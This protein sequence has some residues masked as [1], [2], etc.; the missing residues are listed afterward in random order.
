MVRWYLSCYPKFCK[1]LP[2]NP[3][4]AAAFTDESEKS[5]YKIHSIDFYICL[6]SLIFCVLHLFF[7][8]C[9]EMKAGHENYIDNEEHLK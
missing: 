3:L 1:T 2:N 9:F 8:Y 7:D 6:C 4:L 5:N